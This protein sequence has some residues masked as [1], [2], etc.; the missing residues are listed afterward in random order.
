MDTINMTL[1]LRRGGG[2]CLKNL[3]RFPL[4]VMQNSMVSTKI[5]AKIYRAQLKECAYHKIQQYYDQN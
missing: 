5:P 1:Y 2:Q 3:S 4:D